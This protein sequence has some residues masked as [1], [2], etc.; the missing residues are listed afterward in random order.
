MTGLLQHGPSGMISQ[1]EKM[2]T[3]IDLDE[4]SVESIDNLCNQS[5]FAKP[6]L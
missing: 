5:E 4:E 2:I 6:L 1:I 3:Q